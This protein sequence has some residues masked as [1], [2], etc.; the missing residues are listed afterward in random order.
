MRVKEHES[1]EE[2][3]SIYLEHVDLLEIVLKNNEIY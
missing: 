1:E 3:I 2:R